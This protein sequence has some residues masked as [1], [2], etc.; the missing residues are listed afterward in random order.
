MSSLLL[1]LLSYPAVYQ[2]PD[3]GTPADSRADIRVVAFLGVECPLARLYAQRLNELK[4]EFPQ[5]EFRAYAPNRQDSVEEVA[6]LQQFLDFPIQKSS[7]EATRLGAARSPEVFLLRDGVI[8]YSG[9]I[10]DQYA[11][12]RHR[13]GPTRRDLAVAIQ[14]ILAGQSVSVPRVEPAGCHLNIDAPQTRQAADAL[15]IMHARCATC[16]HPETAA[17]FSLLTCDDARAWHATIREVITQGRMPP[18]GAEV[19]NFV[20]DRRL[21]AQER[22]K[23]L[24]WIDAGCPQGD[25]V[26]APQFRSEWSFTPDILQAAPDFQVPATGTLDYQ[27]FKLPVFE[28][29]TW[30][31]A[32]EIRG[33]R[34]VH[35]VNALIEPADAKPALRYAVDGDDYLATMVAGNPGIQL[36]PEMAKLIPAHWRIRLEIH[37]EPIG[38]PIL[39]KTAIAL[40]LASQ[41]RRRVMTRMLLKNDIVLPP[42]S[43]ATFENEWRLERDYTLLAIFPHM[44]LRGKSM[45]VRAI[46]PDQAEEVLLDVP[47]YDYAWQDRYELARP[48]SLPAGTLIR[49]TA[50]W[51]NTRDN[52]INPDP[53]QTVRAGKRASDEMF[54]CS[55]DVYE[56]QDRS[57][58]GKQFPWL[59]IAALALAQVYL[60]IRRRNRQHP[61]T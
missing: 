18:W 56:T 11:P 41:P 6:E 55:L 8:A 61:V 35:H 46:P 34:A 44:H 5:V 26:P 59:P 24:A 52:P 32:V 30:V 42:D 2:T 20:N 12:G 40:K 3:A 33:S 58:S 31:N 47:R 13:P 14:E 27:E 28:Q 51:D 15:A 60:R 39:D 17:P 23:L 29:D 49:V 37:Y 16:H 10:D 25:D 43:T 36:P 45:C 1:L 57:G 9:R 19:G 7:D 21:S 53:S 4:A 50:R 48:R 38:R 54:Q 22:E